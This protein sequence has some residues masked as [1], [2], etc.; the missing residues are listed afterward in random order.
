[1]DL[2]TF[3]IMLYM[4]MMMAIIGYISKQQ[5]RRW[6]IKELPV[7]G[8]SP[9]IADNCTVCFD[10]CPIILKCPCGHK[11]CPSCLTE[12]INIRD[13][14]PSC[15]ED[16][17]HY[18]EYYT[19]M[20]HPF[21]LPSDLSIETKTKLQLAF[22]L[23]C[24]VAD[25]ETVTKC[26]EIGVN[27]NEEGFFRLFPLHLVSQVDVAK[28]LIEKGGAIVNQPRG[29]DGLTALYMGCY[30]GNFEIVKYLVEKGAKVNQTRFDGVGPLLI[31]A[32]NGH[33][34]I[35]QYLL[36][37]NPRAYPHQ[38]KRNGVTALAISCYMGHSE[39]VKCLVENG[40]NVDLP[41]YFFINNTDVKSKRDVY[42]TPLFICS[43]KRNLSGV[44]YLVN[45]GADLNL[46]N[47]DGLTAL[48]MNLICQ[49]TEIA[50]ILLKNGA[51]IDITKQFL[52]KQNRFLPELDT[53]EELQKE[54]EENS[55]QKL[56]MQKQLRNQEN[57]LE[58]WWNAGN[59]KRVRELLAQLKLSNLEET[60]LYVCYHRLL[61][62]VN[63][64]K[65]FMDHENF[66]NF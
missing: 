34:E 5:I 10:F 17:P 29:S 36:R 54:I 28:Y 16:L 56:N 13:K 66:I 63:R 1:M 40:A 41:K 19:I 21:Q 42:V 52:K 25:L 33:L 23:I 38:S 35:V 65:G 8:N 58:F 61:L 50:K 9:K 27:V 60:P 2:D 15:R 7:L 64:N 47:D 59:Y 53:L 12:W 31:S 22:P 44:E 26:K 6:K 4:F 14:C 39:I 49:N 48:A 20:Y 57:Y 30:N 45:N 55:K 32:Q 62:E 51:N 3:R 43:E 37:Q 46:T 18:F 11:L 24:S